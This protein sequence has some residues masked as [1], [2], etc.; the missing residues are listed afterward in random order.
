MVYVSSLML[1]ITCIDLSINN[2]SGNIPSIMGN[3][4]GLHT[5]NLSYNSLIGEI[6]SS[7]GSLA[8][9]ESLDLSNNKLK[10]RIPNEM[11]QVSFLS[12]F[13]VAN[14]SLCGRI[15]EGRQFNTFNSTYF[16]RNHGLCGFP[17]NNK[18]CGC[19]EMSNYGIQTPLLG[20]ED[21]EEGKIPWHWYVE[22]MA[23]VSIGFWGVFGILAAK[24]HWR[25]RFIH[26]LD[27]MAISLLNGLTKR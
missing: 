21:D 14:N 17:L 15:P 27:E 19:G 24:R 6:P 7:F 13:I 10:G 25:R 18:S 23:S 26:A 9:L 2:L 16:S 1:L 3:L 8:E 12:F 4:K 22:W 20:K 5:L 11:L